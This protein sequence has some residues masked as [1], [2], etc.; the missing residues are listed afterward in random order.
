MNYDYPHYTAEETKVQGV[1]VTSF[2]FY[3]C[4]RHSWEI[5]LLDCPVIP[6]VIIGSTPLSES[7][8]ISVLMGSHPPQKF[9]LLHNLFPYQGGAAMVYLEYRVTDFNHN[10]SGLSRIQQFEKHNSAHTFGNAVSPL[11][12]FHLLIMPMIQKHVDL[13]VICACA[14]VYRHWCQLPV[15]ALTLFLP[16]LGLNDLA[17]SKSRTKS[18]WKPWGRTSQMVLN[19]RCF[20][21]MEDK[22]H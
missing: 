16:E 17:Y 8:G 2:R 13:M 1:D 9:H 10:P 15:R 3:R 11:A 21:L 19:L 7:I 20:P 12:F 6:W 4:N 5:P 14:I 22:V 18:S